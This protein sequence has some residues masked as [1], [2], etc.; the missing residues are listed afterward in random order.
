MT[1][2]TSL[3]TGQAR[4]RFWLGWLRFGVSAVALT[5]FGC[6]HRASSEY[7]LP[8]ALGSSSSDVRRV[9]GSPKESFKNPKDERLTTEW[10]YN[11]GL[12]AVFERDQ[13]DEIVLHNG[14]LVDYPGFLAYT[15]ETGS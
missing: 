10:Y 1:A 15:N 7:G 3:V 12:V 11:H 2:K 4:N 14:V 6:Q 8:V 5:I 13:L 9:L